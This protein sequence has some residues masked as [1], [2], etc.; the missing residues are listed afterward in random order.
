MSI[1]LIMAII[2]T[3]CLLAILVP[4]VTGY[5]GWSC[6]RSVATGWLLFVVS[7]LFQDIGSPLL[8]RHFHGTEGIEAV[9]SDQP[10]TL[11]ALVGGWG[12]GLVGTGIGVG[13]RMLTRRIRKNS[14]PG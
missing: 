8:A 13:L 10:G 7:Y 3:F 1:Q 11:A 12:V 14:A 5:R 9:A 2:P 6:H 4:V